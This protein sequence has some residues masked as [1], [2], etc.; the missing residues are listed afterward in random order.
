MRV[1]AIA[2]LVVTAGCGQGD[3][4][5]V[6]VEDRTEPPPRFPGFEPFLASRMDKLIQPSESAEHALTE[7]RMLRISQMV[8]PVMPEQTVEPG[9]PDARLKPMLPLKARLRGMF[10]PKIIDQLKPLW[11]KDEWTRAETELAQETG[12]Y[13]R[14]IGAP[15]LSFSH[16]SQK[17]NRDN[18]A[19][20]VAWFRDHCSEPAG[21]A[22]MILTMDTGPF[23]GLAVPR[24]VALSKKDEQTFGDGLALQL[25]RMREAREPWV[26]RV[27]KGG[28]VL[29]SRVVSRAPDGVIS[30]LKLSHKEPTDVGSYGWKLHL[31]AHGE[32]LHLYVG[33]DGRFL[34]YF[35]SW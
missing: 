11:D 26:L 31:L 30:E 24:G 17:A 27:Q 16:G 3:P 34:F 13:C 4:P 23:G 19:R 7:L 28:R 1:F 22:S 6:P 18:L 9:A 12:A 35:H 2:A 8:A 25:C 14:E 15:E 10:V 5:T 32:Y 20:L 21:Y 33:P 29:W